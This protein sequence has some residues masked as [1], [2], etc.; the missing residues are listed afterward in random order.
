[1]ERRIKESI[2]FFS[3]LLFVLFS[4]YAQNTNKQESL[5]HVIN[6]LEAQ[7]HVQFNYAEDTIEAVFLIPPDTSLSLKEAITYLETQTGLLFSILSDGIILVK[8]REAMVLCGYVK[9]KDNLQPLASATVQTLKNS[10]TTDE[11]GF[12]QI[13]IENV[14]QSI[15]I[16]FLG[17]KTIIKLTNQFSKTGCDDIFLF[18]NFQSLSEVVVSNYIASGINKINNGSYEINF[19]DF[20]ILP[21]LIDNDV[22]QSVQAFPGIQSINETVSNINIRGGTHDQNLILW[23]DIKMYQSGHFFGLISMYNPQ[24]TH[25]VSLR[26][27]GSD[28]SYT[29]GVSGTI[30]MQT[31][32]SV[33]NKLNAT[34]GINLTDANAFVDVP[35]NKTSSIQVA[36][37]KSISDFIE[38]PTYSAFFDRI[39]QN[40]EVSNNTTTITNTDKTFDFYDTSLRWIY[41]I[42]DK[43]EL[44]INFINVFNELQFN[45]NAVVNDEEES[46]KSNLTQYSI[47]GA[48]HYNRIW[49]DK[50]Q[51]T[52]EAYET[53]YKL[54]A[55]NVDILDSQRFLQENIVSETSLKLKSNYRFNNALHLLSGYHFVETQ[56]TNL[57][58]ID[59]P[60]FRLL[61]SEVVRTHGVFS[62]LGYKSKNRNSNLNFGVRY[63][64]IEKFSKSIWEPRLSF[65]Q[66][67]LDFFTVEV[68]GEF[69]HQNTS[70]VINF[71]NDFLGIEKRRWQLSNNKDI[72][73]ITS[74]QASLGLNYG[75]RGWLFNIEG[76]IKHVDGITAQSQG[77]QNQFEF[78]KSKGVNRVIGVDVLF[79]KHINKFSTWISYA[80]MHNEYQFKDLQ[81]N[82]F[83]SN[84]NIKHAATLGMTY[85]LTNLKLSAGLNWHS[86]KPTTLPVTGNEIVNDEVNY[87]AVNISSLEDYLRLDISA[88]YNF[89]LTKKTKANVG[90]SLWNVLNKENQINRFYKINSGEL[91]ETN[92]RSLGL[93][94]N[95]VLNIYF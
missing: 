80:Y 47:A 33:N 14:T 60:L 3:F 66:R 38:T 89:K 77:F 35:I 70:Q 76:Y 32:Q 8:P 54:K 9:D 61:V 69:K 16:R 21:G 39:S 92:Q 87:E 43:D 19:S 2:L 44:R 55:V 51:T 53:D 58:D 62:Q 50:L 71:Q 4:S 41:K 84:Y 34:L 13:K 20:D 75:H 91:N 29:D 93:T 68:L 78:A 40:T 37:R 22:L 5:A 18:P 64:F 30:S 88:L 73:V 90:I 15:T 83:P 59:T 65:S 17:Y 23:D 48:L 11:N 52:F 86:G 67:F 12:F 36:A 7:Y 74:K 25:S 1:M 31:N 56:V 26:K 95:A 24:I 46:R 82:Y 49:N 85:G 79:R 57:D 42:G 10:T 81:P 6:V 94:P 63:N 28:V 45:E 27:N 72:P